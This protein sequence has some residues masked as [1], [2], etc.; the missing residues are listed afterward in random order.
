MNNIRL[1]PTFLITRSGSFPAIIGNVSI[2]ESLINS[3]LYLCG[4]IIPIRMINILQ[5]F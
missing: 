5:E 1:K 2:I 3:I 4:K